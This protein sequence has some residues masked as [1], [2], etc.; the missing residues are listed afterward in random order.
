MSAIRATV[1]NGQIVP[2]HPVEWPDGTELEVRPARVAVSQGDD[3]S[4]TPEA[5]EEWIAWYRSLEPIVM[6]PE[7]E[8]EWKRARDEQKAFELAH[9]EERSK[10]LEGLFE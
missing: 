8:A 6:S 7:E 10:K 1:Q 4:N 2:D 3:W 5:I 9:W